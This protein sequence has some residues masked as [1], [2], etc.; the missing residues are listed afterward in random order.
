MGK[1]SSGGAAVSCGHEKRIMTRR[2]QR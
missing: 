2:S 1:L